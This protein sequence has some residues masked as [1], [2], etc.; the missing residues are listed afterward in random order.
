[1]Q[2]IRTRHVFFNR[3]GLFSTPFSSSAPRIWIHA[4]S[5][6]E[7]QSISK[8]VQLLRAGKI[9]VIITVQNVHAFS[10]LQKKYEYCDDVFLGFFPLDFWP[11]SYLAWRSLQPQLALAVDSELWPEHLYQ[12]KCHG[13]PFWLINQRHSEKTYQRF[14]MFPHVFKFFYSHIDLIWSSSKRD[15]QHMQKLGV[16]AAKCRYRGNLKC[17]SYL[18]DQLSPQ[19]QVDLKQSIGF[20]TGEPAVVLLAASSWPGEE[21]LLIQVLLRCLELC[22]PVKLILAPRHPARL[23]EFLNDV[24]KT[25][26]NYQIRSKSLQEPQENTIYIADTIGEL[27]K[28]YQISDVAFIGKS[29][30]KNMGGQNPI[31]AAAFGCAMVFGPNMENF[32]DISEDLVN[33]NAAVQGQSD[34]DIREQLIYLLSHADSRRQQT[35][36]A[37][38]WLDENKD[39]AHHI[40][41]AIESALLD[42]DK[43]IDQDLPSLDIFSGL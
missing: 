42:E 29:S 1:M 27:R 24:N 5:V 34:D 17:D 16:S 32:S 21:K 7:S 8:L 9:N 13:V 11:C 37:K 40:Y 36:A 26:L 23:K 39:C 20:H 4:A 3:L 41:Q 25:K 43:N 38:L 6:G 30:D 18:Q 33:N 10:M 35:L 14:L 2:H 19:Q 31:E 22:M 15:Y 28:F 12:A